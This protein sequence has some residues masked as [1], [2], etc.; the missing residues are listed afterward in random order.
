MNIITSKIKIYLLQITHI[1]FTYLYNIK[2]ICYYL[3]YITTTVDV[4]WCILGR[5]PYN[6]INVVVVVVV[7]IS[8]NLIRYPTRYCI[9]QSLQ[10]YIIDKKSN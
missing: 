8:N 1:V 6:S 10:M 4:T 5:R 2:V 9:I 3:Y 7:V